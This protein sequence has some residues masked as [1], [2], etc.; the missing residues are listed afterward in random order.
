MMQGFV[1]IHLHAHLPFV[2]HPEH[3]RFLEEDW[4]YE[5]I[6]E[7]YIPLVSRFETLA[8]EGIPFRVSFT[9]TPP[10]VQMLRDDLLQTRYGKHLDRLCELA[11]KE[12]HRTR[13]EPRLHDTARFYHHHFN[14]TRW[15]WHERYRRDLVGAFRRLQDRGVV[16]IV[17]CGATHGFLPLMQTQPEAVRAQIRIAAAHYRLHFGRDPVGIWLPE[18]GYY[19]GVER[20]LS[21]EGIR[22]F[23]VDTHGILDATP[24]PRYGVF[25][26]LYTP[27][28]VAAFGRDP[29][30]SEQVWS[31]GTGYPGDPV[32]REFYRDV[33]YDLD[34]DYVRPYIQATGERKNTGFKYHR[35]TGRGMEKDLYDWRAA[36]RQADRHA[37]NF[38]FNREK[39]IVHL[40]MVMGA[41]R[42]VV[43][44]PYDAELFGHWWFEGPVFLEMLIRKVA[45]DQKTFELVSPS[46]YLRDNPTQQVAT[47]PLCSWGAGG[48][49]GVWLDGSN[50]WIYRHLHRCADSMIRMA[51]DFREPTDLERRALNQAA[52]ELLLAQSSDWAFIMKT[53]TMV[54][55]AVQRTKDHV[56]RFLRLEDELRRGA[57]DEAW[58]AQVEGRDN[59]FPELDYRVY[60]A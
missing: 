24:R 46:D 3:E 18:C 47:P 58:L 29:E 25:A 23:F 13:H 35:I 40:A 21:E 59:L 41:R 32:Y 27:A 55:Y 22:Y 8:D 10:L 2:R 36:F 26:P 48:Y 1:V 15:L 54:E 37:G 5:A 44:A 34:Y 53:G 56:L 31:A 49:A 50:D 39:Q 52:R 43:V 30:S 38:M 9:L 33:G 14:H 17:T 57:I 6:T 16:E 12:L 7:T 4:L 51:S 11:D 45:H 28:G 20:F 60:C 19:P 42:P